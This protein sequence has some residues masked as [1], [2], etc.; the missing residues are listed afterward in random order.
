MMFKESKYPLAWGHTH[1]HTLEDPEMKTNK[2]SHHE[3]A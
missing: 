2:P 3:L 1:T